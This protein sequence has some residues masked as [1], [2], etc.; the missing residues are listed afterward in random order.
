M[1]CDVDAMDGAVPNSS[2]Q[3]IVGGI[4]GVGML[5]GGKGVNWVRSR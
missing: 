3:C 2:S 5:E 1:M 4:V